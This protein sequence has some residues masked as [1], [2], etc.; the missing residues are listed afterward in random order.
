MNAFRLSKIPLP[1]FSKGAF[2]SLPLPKGDLEGFFAAAHHDFDGTVAIS[3]ALGIIDRLRGVFFDWKPDGK[4]LGSVV[5]F[6]ICGGKR[7]GCISTVFA[8]G[9][10]IKI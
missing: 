9:H 6:A 1:P 8:V 7:T 4:Q 10:V 3:G 2:E 5:T